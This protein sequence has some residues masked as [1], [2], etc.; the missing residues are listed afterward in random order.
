MVISRQ[1]CGWH[2]NVRYELHCSHWA[3]KYRA[4]MFQ[5]QFHSQNLGQRWSQSS[6]ITKLVFVISLLGLQNL[7]FVG[8]RNM[9]WTKYYWQWCWK[10]KYA[11]EKEAKYAPDKN[12][13]ALVGWWIEAGKDESGSADLPAVCLKVRRSSSSTAVWTVWLAVALVEGCTAAVVHLHL[14]HQIEP[15][16]LVNVSNWTLVIQV[17]TRQQLSSLD[18]VES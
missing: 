17:C 8:K 11:L 18:K 6:W 10:A 4:K 15:A 16:P 9:G 2:C 1:F 13:L 14:Q 5:F 3:Q 12:L 7:F